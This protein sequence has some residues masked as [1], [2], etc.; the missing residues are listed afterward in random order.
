MNNPGW[1]LLLQQ[2]IQAVRSRQGRTALQLLQQASDLQPGSREVR[3]WLGQA[4]RLCGQVTL[5]EKTFRSLLASRP[6]DAETALALAFLLREHGRLDEHGQVLIQFAQQPAVETPVLLQIAGVLRDSNRFHDAIKVMQD[7]VNRENEPAIHHFRLARL[8]Q[9]TGQY[10]AALQSYRDTLQRDANQGGAWL[11]L[12]T[13]QHFDDPRNPDWQML[14][15]S[16]EPA[17][18]PE[19]AMC[20]AFARAKGFDDLKLYGQAWVHLQEGNRLRQLSQPWDQAAWQT[21][22]ERASL[23]H[24]ESLITN[25]PQRRP[26]FIVGMLRAG[27]T[28]LEQLLDQHPQMTARGEL[29]F[30]AHAWKLWHQ[31]KPSRALAE[32][33][34]AQ[35]WKHMRQDGPEEQF[36]IDKNPLN[37][38]FLPLIAN[39]MPEAKVLH[40]QRDGRDS[41]LSCFMQVFQHPDSAFANSLDDLVQ[42]YHDYRQ[43]AQQFGREMR[44]QV[45]TLAYEDLV[46]DSEKTLQAVQEFLELPSADTGSNRN[47]PGQATERPIRTA[48]AWQARQE[49]HRRSLGRWQNYRE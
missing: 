9:G 39:L 3:H 30:L 15:S 8:Y 1:Q 13:L 32:E 6:L 7:V 38:R 36:Y 18:N 34:A 21:Q 42:V 11:G 14:V 10:D 2:G 5:A 48:S 44:G 19:A 28:L 22:F 40:L 41:C 49:I 17:G 31:E 47:N 37:F 23:Q 20:L 33:L 27:T 12:A 4:Q 43:L 16:P 24:A 45:F 46:N 25:P 29:N 35:V 26:V